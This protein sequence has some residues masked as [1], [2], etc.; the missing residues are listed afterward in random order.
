MLLQ[1]AHLVGDLLSVFGGTA[2]ESTRGICPGQAFPLFQINLEHCGFAPGSRARGAQLASHRTFALVT[3]AWPCVMA[4]HRDGSSGSALLQ[5]DHFRAS[6]RSAPT[7]KVA[8][9]AFLWQC[10]VHGR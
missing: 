8:L 4:S 6:L 3:T 7:E 10:A 9:A 5:A 2:V 1:P